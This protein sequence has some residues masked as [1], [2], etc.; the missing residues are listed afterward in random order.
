M[1]YIC[2]Q[3][4]TQTSE[5][6]N[7]DKINHMSIT[8]KSSAEVLCSKKVAIAQKCPSLLPEVTEA[9]TQFTTVITL[10]EKCHQVYN[11]GVTDD[12]T[13]DQLLP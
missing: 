9:Y 3:S 2:R 10:F 1:W 4:R 11:G 7:Y 6:K 5:G 8:Q 13:I 12:S